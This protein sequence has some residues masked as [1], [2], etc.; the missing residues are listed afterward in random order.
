LVFLD[1]EQHIRRLAAIGDVHRTVLGGLFW[2]GW[3]L[4]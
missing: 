4:G 2:L 1:T 3:R